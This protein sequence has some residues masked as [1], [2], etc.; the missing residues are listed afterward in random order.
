MGGKQRTVAES[1]ISFRF[2]VTVI[3][4][5]FGASL[6][7]WIATELVPPDFLDREDVYRHT[8]GTTGTRL[9]DV[10]R[11]YDPFHS[12]WYEIVLVIF[13]VAL[14]LCVVTRWRQLV[15]GSWRP[16]APVDP[17]ELE[18]APF[19]FRLSWRLLESG[20][21]RIKDPL[22]HY[23]ERYGRAEQADAETLRQRFARVAA[24]LRKRGYAVVSREDPSGISF[25]AFSGR[26]RSPGSM[27]FHVGILVITIGGVIGSYGGW[28]ETMF[29]REGSSAPLPRDSVLSLH[30]ERFEIVTTERL[31][32][33][34]YI[35][36][37]SVV[38]KQGN[39]LAAG[40]VQVNHPMKVAGRRIYQ[41][42]FSVD[43]NAFKRARIVYSLRESGAHGTVDLEPGAPAGLMDSSI[44][45]TAV[46]YLPDF[47]MGPDGPFSASAFPSNP[48]LEVRVA[49]A[50][51]TESGWLF[52]YHG[53]F[54]K[55]FAAP[56]DLVLDAC[57]PVYY[58][59]LEVSASPGAG[60]LFAGF[61]AATL[62]L[63]LMYLCNPR[64]LKG[65]SGAGELL[66]A[67]TEYRWKASFERELAG[68]R[69]TIR[70]EF[71][72]RG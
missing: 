13:F 33:K 26:W 17:R 37:V 69:E 31:E 50:G 6:A 36:T 64:V 29:V 34:D 53:D 67:G 2:A 12:F 63:L 38:D 21:D 9:V 62:G 11:L 45:V 46:R 5:L 8:W 14:L 19:A 28:R 44:T 39:A 41:S 72:P 20:E 10:L 59:G 27:L 71:G 55:R 66:V 35:S 58:T 40:T 49:S 52:L 15:L 56:V 61:A 70:K 22:V 1:F 65:V 16:A 54:N 3:A 30:V 47:R 68:V 60:V 25:A 51:V 43:E 7:G 4:I 24:L 57:E 48:A 23:G 32:I 18:G 42:E